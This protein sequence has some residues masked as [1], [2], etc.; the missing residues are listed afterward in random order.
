MAAVSTVSR[1]AARPAGDLA[2]ECQTGVD[3]NQ[4]QDCRV[5]GVVN[6]V[7]EYW[8]DTV[9]GYREAPTTLFT[10]QVQTGCGYA[11]SAVGPFYCPVDGGV[12]VDLGF[13]DVLESRFGAR[14]GPFAE[15]YVLA[16]EYGHHVQNL[17]GTSDRARGRDH[18]TRQ[19][20]GSVGAPSR[21]LRGR[22]GE[23]RG[24]DR[25]RRSS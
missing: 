4:S 1:S 22:V 12:Y 11:S 5:V 15:A 16:H 2:A 7:Q 8:R 18:R 19:L 13:F 14:G 21:L 3:A 25:I 10:G 24:C 9:N 6:S 23:Q 17:L 20:V